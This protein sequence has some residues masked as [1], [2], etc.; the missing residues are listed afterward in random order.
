MR[1][2]QWQQKTQLMPQMRF[3]LEYE[4]ICIE[5]EKKAVCVMIKSFMTVYK[6]Y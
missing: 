1:H 4:L 6:K 2:Y 5:I 3:A